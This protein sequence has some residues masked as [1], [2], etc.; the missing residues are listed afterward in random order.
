VDGTGY[1]TFCGI[2]NFIPKRHLTNP[3]NVELWLKVSSSVLSN[4]MEIF[5][6]CFVGVDFTRLMVYLS[7]KGIQKI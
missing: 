7:S 5:I 4:V 1:D 3:D 6:S 2:G